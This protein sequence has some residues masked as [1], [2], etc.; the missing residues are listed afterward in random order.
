MLAEIG[1]G[2]VPELIVINKADAADPMVLARLLA[3]EPHAVVV[4]ARTG[5]GIDEVLAAIE[6]DLPRPRSRSTRCA[7]RAG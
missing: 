4:S 5:E 6:A 7:V 2:D 1:A 3:R